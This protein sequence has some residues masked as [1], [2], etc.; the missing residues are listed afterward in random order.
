MSL[1]VTQGTGEREKN[2]MDGIAHWIIPF[3]IPQDMLM[4]DAEF[5]SYRKTFQI[6]TLIQI[7]ENI[8][9]YCLIDPHF[10]DYFLDGF[11][12]TQ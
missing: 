6:D 9:K 12:R 1:P 5:V 3:H 8:G 2:F 11:A 4:W 10:M 7:I